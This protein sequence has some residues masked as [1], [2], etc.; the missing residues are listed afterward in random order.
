M[1]RFTHPDL[2]GQTILEF[3]GDLAT[4]AHPA[5]TSNGRA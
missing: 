5:Q 3:L 4:P 2:Y 1:F